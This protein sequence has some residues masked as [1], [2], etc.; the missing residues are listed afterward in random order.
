[1]HELNLLGGINLRT[2]KGG[3]RLPQP[4]RLAVLAYLLLATP[5]G[6]RTRDELVAMFWPESDQAHARASLRKAVHGLRKVLG[7]GTITGRGERLR[8]DPSRLQC[9]AVHFEELLD[10]GRTA[11][12]ME[13]YRG[14]LLEGFHVSGV[15]AFERWLD[16][17]R[18][19]LLRRAM[20]ATVQLAEAAEAS[21]E[22]RPAVEWARRAVRVDPFDEATARWAASMLVRLGRRTA[23]IRLLELLV[24]RLESEWEVAASTET[25]ELLRRLRMPEAATRPGRDPEPE[26]GPGETD[27]A[28]LS[29]NDEPSAA[30][31]ASEGSG[32]RADGRRFPRA[33]HRRFHWVLGAA[34]ALTLVLVGTFL[35][36]RTP[37]AVESSMGSRTVAVLPFEANDSASGVW[38]EAVSHLLTSNLGALPATEAIGPRV[39]AAAAGAAP[40][41]GPARSPFPPKEL[42]TKMGVTWVVRGWVVETEGR[43]VASA[44]LWDA[45]HRTWIR[46]F[47]ASESTD[48]VFTLADRLT[49]QLVSGGLTAGRPD[50]MSPDLPEAATSSAAALRAFLE[51]E[52]HFRR[53]EWPEAARRYEAALEGDSTFALAYFRLGETHRELARP[54]AARL[55]ERALAFPERMRERQRS[56]VRGAL[57]TVQRRREAVDTLRQ[58]TRLHPFDPEAWRQLGAAYFHVGRR[59]LASPEDYRAALDRAIELDP[60]WVQPYVHL[61]E[62]AFFREDEARARKLVEGLRDVTGPTAYGLGFGLSLDLAWGGAS[63]QRRALIAMD[64]LS[65]RLRGPLDRAMTV[66]EMTPGFEQHLRRVADAR[67]R[68]SVSEAERV[69]TRSHLLRSYPRAGRAEAGL[70]ILRSRMQMQGSRERMARSILQ[71]HTLGYRAP[72]TAEEALAALEALATPSLRQRFWMGAF[73]LATGDS[74][75]YRGQ[76]DALRVLA[77]AEEAGTVGEGGRGPGPPPPYTGLVVEAL[78]V[79]SRAERDPIEAI[80]VL[81]MVHDSRDPELTDDGILD[82]LRYRLGILYRE[83][84]RMDLSLRHFNAQN[85]HGDLYIALLE[86][87]RGRTKFAMGRHDEARGHYERFARWWRDCDPALRP[88]RNE[89][90]T[91]L[92]GM[93]TAR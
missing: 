24:R 12:A 33:R 58:I 40:E 85:H 56:L 78:E 68:S 30:A 35:G 32:G 39:A 91:A 23:A 46:G 17:E 8:V 13:L 63:D 79:L 70:A 51:G 48:S 82:Y 86:L 90:L 41:G 71:W 22:R 16:L 36:R 26:A 73:A 80:T 10:E 15:P 21:G 77:R 53:G 93:F 87:E 75:L 59:V 2:E 74:A 81:R 60:G 62:D 55:L 20:D 50:L 76:V 6:F 42:E 92:N 7:R 67:F 83:T 49:V 4:K 28:G 5:R 44:E 29:A 3:E 25:S 64:T 88:L 43:L 72:G 45:R 1:M 18:Q 54:D 27:G 65:P 52:Q 47:R 57:L 11:E 84:G 66:L 37:A 38:G 31:P 19:R 9:D 61:V 89:A 34:G 14:T 69:S